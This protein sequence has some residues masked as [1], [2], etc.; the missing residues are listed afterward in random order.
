M[1]ERKVTGAEVTRMHFES[2]KMVVKRRGLRK[3]HA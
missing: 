2:Q 3:K 1:P